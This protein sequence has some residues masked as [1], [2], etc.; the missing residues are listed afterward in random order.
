LIKTLILS[1]VITIVG[2]E[3][4]V[5]Q[6]RRE[7][8]SPD[9]I[10]SIQDEQ[11]SGKRI[12]LYL[13]FAARR[14]DA[15]REKI[16]AGDAKGG[17][18]VQQYLSEYNSIWD[19]VADS[20]E[21]ARQQR[22][23]LDKP[24][25]EVQSKGTEFLRYMQSLQG[26]KSASRSDYEFTLEEAIDT[27]KDEVAEVKK[28]AF[29]EVNARKPPTDLPAAPPPRS[30]AGSDKSGSDKSGSEEGPPRKKSR[31]PSQNQ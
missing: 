26:G 11:D 10:N 25:K 24:I 28:G 13:Q 15:V 18:A 16:T 21:T 3:T 2:L 1:I 23:S 27:T 9:E 8:L 31:T 14:L 17:R 5:C 20:L 22:A 4:A 7:F 12:L 29:P 19:A 30:K 6:N